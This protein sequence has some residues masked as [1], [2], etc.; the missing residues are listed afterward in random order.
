MKLSYR[1]FW[2]PKKGSSAEEYEDSFAPDSHQNQNQKNQNQES[3]NQNDAKTSNESNDSNDSKE[4]KESKESNN[5]NYSREFKDLKVF[6]CAV[7][8]GATE[9]SFSGQW[10]RLLCTAYV[11]NTL[12]LTNLADLQKN[13]FDEVSGKD[14]PWYAEE[15]LASGAFAT[16]V[17][18]S[19]KEERKAI[20]WSVSALGDSCFFH[21]RDNK[22][23]Q[24]TPLSKWEDFSYSPALLSTRQESNVGVVETLVETK[25][26]ALKGDI[27]YL[28]TDAVSKWF[29]HKTAVDGDAIALL[30]KIA[31]LEEFQT[32]VDE[33]RSVKEADGRPMMPND[34]VT[35][36]RI[37]LS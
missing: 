3:Q 8:D 22:V 9:T 32:L 6:R 25:G 37:R 2:L 4:S 7:A 33:Q 19:L 28:M 16:I 5:S 24:S 17:G 15:K 12:D 30:E 14:L 20:N 23:L 31:D 34:D 10:A 29:L 18:L 26:Q 21:L 27:L 35:W 13:W 36:T 11:Q 1:V